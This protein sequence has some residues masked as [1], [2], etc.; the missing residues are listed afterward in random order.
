MLC[1]MTQNFE[2][3]SPSAQC[4]ELESDFESIVLK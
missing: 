1:R 2:Y 3:E 4:F